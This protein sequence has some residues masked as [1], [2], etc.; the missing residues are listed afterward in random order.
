MFLHRDNGP[1]V[2]ETSPREQKGFVPD[3]HI[4]NK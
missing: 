2:S 4:K 3:E 1:K